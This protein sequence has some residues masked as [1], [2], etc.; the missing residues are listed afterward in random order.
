MKVFNCIENEIE[1]HK[2]MLD[3]WRTQDAWYRNSTAGRR[4][5]ALYEYAIEVLESIRDNCD[6]GQS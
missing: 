2:E 4:Q 5:K 3:D 6:E 1:R